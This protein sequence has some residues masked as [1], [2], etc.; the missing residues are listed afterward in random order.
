MNFFCS[1]NNSSSSTSHQSNLV[2][3]LVILFTVSFH[4]IL[5]VEAFTPSG[6]TIPF[7]NSVMNHRMITAAVRKSLARTT[8][9]F[10][11]NFKKHKELLPCSTSSSLCPCFTYSTQIFANGGNTNDQLSSCGVDITT[12]EYLVQQRL[13]VEA[14]KRQSRKDAL[15]EDR[16]RNLRIKQLLEET[17]V[18]EQEN[19]LD[20]GKGKNSSF[21]AVYPIPNL[22]QV[23]VSVDKTLR[24]ELKMNGRE[25]RGRV[26]I[27]KSSD[28]CKSLKGLKFEM[29]AFFRALRKSTYILSASLPTV[30]NDGT[31]YSPGDENNHVE[32]K[33]PYK[34]FWD[35]NSDEDVL[36]TFDKAEEFFQTYNEGLTGEDSQKKKLKR[37][38]ILIHVRKDP[39]AP[40][41]LPLPKY[42]EN[43]PNP[44]ETETMTML[45][46]YS[47][48]PGGVQ[49]PEEFALFLR[50][51]WKPFDALGRVYVAKEGI[52]A[53]M[54]IPTNVLHNFR[55]CCFEIPELGQYMENGINIDPIPLTIEEFAVAGT[56]NGRP[57]PPFRNLHVRVRQQIVA[58]GLDHELDWDSAG[59]DMPPMEWHQALKEAKKARESDDEGK[60][61][62]APLIFDCRNNYETSVGIFAGA[63][64]LDT[65]NFRESWDILKEK[66]K[67]KPKDTPIM[68]YCTGGIRCVKVGAYLTQ[69]L[70]FTNVSR[71]AGGVIAYDRTLNDQAPGEEPLFKGT[72]YVFDGR[73]G[74]RITDDALGE[75][76]TCGGKTN[77][78]SN[79]QNTNC[80]K[81]M[82][83][84]D[85]CRDFYRGACSEICKNR[86]LNSDVFFEREAPVSANKYDSLDDYAEGYSSPLSPFYDEIKKNTAQLMSTGV[87]MISDTAQGRLLYN[88]AS[89]TR[90]GRILEIGSFT[91]YATCCFMEGA[92]AAADAIGYTHGYGTRESGPFVMSL[93]RDNRAIDIAASHVNIMSTFGIG[94][95]GAEVASA[96]RETDVTESSMPLSFK[97]KNVG[98][99][100][101]KV[102]DALAYVEAMAKGISGADTKAFDMVFIDADKTRFLQY[103]EACLTS[104]K[105]LK[106][107]GIMV[108]DNTLWKGLVLDINNGVMSNA[109][110]N[111]DNLEAKKSKRAR[112]LANAVHYFNSMIAK[113]SRVEVTLLNIRDGL[114]IIRKK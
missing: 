49:D 72:N 70:G 25:K 96:L 62:S 100:I 63:V 68:T 16:Q 93:E 28:G 31:I 94:D 79:C 11:R 52:N 47:F 9:T 103:V 50:K 66:L 81:R 65:E 76:I 37:P 55:D 58:D 89:M 1:S 7:A 27:E 33:D 78:I 40:A 30:L 42:L 74:R 85:N 56:M 45:S 92:A 61:K 110:L 54:S 5:F 14:A 69:E 98:C 44:E 67:D 57:C 114:S 82:V 86:V 24:D 3:V 21:T 106:K 104:D 29:H 10:T 2:V 99:E 91:G 112:K 38:S 36:K 59:Y 95:K 19:K 22:Y 109:N 64:P 83:Q 51:I 111:A 105:V 48:P 46:F 17:T 43:M 6:T 108:V 15:E 12:N 75:C 73:V 20:S 77:L 84:C 80:H 26:F 87:H 32:G 4:C 35:I 8:T 71:L 34:D 102:D 97:Y 53:Q 13:A 39:N 41:P 18:G 90:E 60:K 88:L 23:R 113:D 107:G 101:L